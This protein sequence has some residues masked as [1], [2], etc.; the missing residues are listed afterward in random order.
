MNKLFFNPFRYFFISILGLTFVF[1]A[2][3]STA[4]A[5]EDSDYVQIA[6]ERKYVGGVEESDLKVQLQLP[7]VDLSNQGLEKSEESTEGF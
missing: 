5:A 4:S 2:Y 1:T 3:L 6:R 7:T